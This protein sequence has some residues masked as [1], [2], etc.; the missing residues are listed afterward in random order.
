MIARKLTVAVHGAILRCEISGAG[1]AVVF[2]HDMGLDSRMWD[3][4]FTR[5]SGSHTVIRY[6]MR[7]FGASDLPDGVAYSHAEDL[8]RVLEYLEI[9]QAH[10][11]GQGLGGKVA[12]DFALRFPLATASMTLVGASPNGWR[13][14]KEFTLLEDR[15]RVVARE[16]GLD[17]ARAV[18][19]ASPLIAPVNESGEA[20]A[21]IQRMVSEYSGWHWTHD[22]TGTFVSPPAMERLREIEAPVLIIVGERGATDLHM[23]A[24]RMQHRFANARKAIM[25]DTGAVPSME[26]PERFNHLV[27]RFVSAVRAPR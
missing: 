17:A 2:L 8:S 21:L 18:W 12:I 14:P 25:L 26:D 11:I 3:F 7:G 16:H 27:S 20:A 22:D 5:F 23:V 10:L 13:P 1:D 24:D 9:Q 4:Q 6:D 15:P 19:S